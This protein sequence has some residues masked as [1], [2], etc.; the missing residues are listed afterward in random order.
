GPPSPPSPRRGRPR[1]RPDDEADESRAP[2]VPVPAVP[3]PADGAREGLERDGPVAVDLE[4][5]GRPA[6]ALGR[7]LAEEESGPG[8]EVGPYVAE[9]EADPAAVPDVAGRRAVRPVPRGDDADDCLL[10]VAAI[11]RQDRVSERRVGVGS[12]HEHAPRRQRHPRDVAGVPPVPF[13]NAVV[14]G[15]DVQR[16]QRR[17]DGPPYPKARRGVSAGRPLGPGVVAGVPVHRHEAAE[18][19]IAEGRQVGLKVLKAGERNAVPP[20]HLLVLELA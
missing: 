13:R 6:V 1:G 15:L 12:Q 9:R 4:G 8:V 10:P 17:L 3:D 14:H 18:L 20:D 5:V 16:P 19:G 2:P 11:P 7:A